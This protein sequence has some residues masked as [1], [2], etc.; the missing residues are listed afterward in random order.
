MN[1]PVVLG[2]ARHLLQVSA[3]ALAS[4]GII[5]ENEVEIVAAAFL[6]IGTGIWFAIEKRRSA[7]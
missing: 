6:A 2:I 3:G 4:R 5:G 7:R 1:S